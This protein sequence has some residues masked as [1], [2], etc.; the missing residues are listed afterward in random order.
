MGA[1]GPG[2]GELAGTQGG[3][4]AAGGL[5]QARGWETGELR[6]GLES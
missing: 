4:E 2:N 6:A 5:K 1:L 3:W